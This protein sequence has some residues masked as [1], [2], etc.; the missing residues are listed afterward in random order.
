MQSGDGQQVCQAGVREPTAEARGKF[1]T[2]GEQQGPG[3]R[4]DKIGDAVSLGGGKFVVLERDS[5]VGPD[6]KKLVFEV[7]NK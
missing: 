2:F 3:S 4:V 5:S 1:V 6:A 7:K